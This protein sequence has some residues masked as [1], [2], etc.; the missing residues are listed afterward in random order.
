MAVIAQLGINWTVGVQFLLF[1][2]TLFI[3]TQVAFRPY[4][5]AFLQREKQTKG[6]ESLAQELLQQAQDLR[7]QYES[8]ARLVNSEIKTIFDG[9]R[10]EANKEYEAIVSK[11][12]SEAARLVEET[13]SKISSQMTDATKKIHE[14]APVV[15]QAITGK[16]LSK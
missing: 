3:L 1:V 15:A 6:G 2:L 16:L 8:K 5:E 13:R 14:E 4:F 9:H 7:G 10:S 12:R 11:A